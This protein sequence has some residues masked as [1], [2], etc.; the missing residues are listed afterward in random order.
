MKQ[1]TY[2]KWLDEWLETLEHNFDMGYDYLGNK[3]E[4]DSLEGFIEYAWGIYQ[5]NETDNILAN[6]EIEG[7]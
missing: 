3:I 2:K 5:E 6:Q 4:Q 1:T 7:M